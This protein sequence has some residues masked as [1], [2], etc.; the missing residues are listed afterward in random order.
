MGYRFVPEYNHAPE[1]HTCQFFRFFSSAILAGPGPFVEIQKC[2]YHIWQRDVT[3]SPLY[4]QC[5][6]DFLGGGASSVDCTYGLA[7]KR[8]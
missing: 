3:T 7:T 5:F 2:C 8:Y 6:E 1:I 4:W